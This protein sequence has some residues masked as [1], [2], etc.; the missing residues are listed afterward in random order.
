ML[1][2]S[3]SAQKAG[4][5]NSLMAFFGNLTKPSAAAANLSTHNA[6]P[7]IV[8]YPV[9]TITE[10]QPEDGSDLAVPDNENPAAVITLA[11]DA[12]VATDQNVSTEQ[13]PGSDA[14][15]VVDTNASDIPDEISEDN[16][17][18]EPYPGSDN[19]SDEELPRHLPIREIT[20]A[21][22]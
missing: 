6:N 2:F 12:T 22:V 1:G 13:E 20:P 10:S 5:G 21:G 7:S 8:Q 15:S 9:T 17:S 19:S 4:P 18:Y 16:Q 14:F 11:S 3:L